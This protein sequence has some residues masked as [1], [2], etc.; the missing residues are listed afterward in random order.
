MAA[1]ICMKNHVLKNRACE[2]TDHE[3]SEILDVT[4]NAIASVAETPIR[5]MLVKSAQHML[6]Q[7]VGTHDYFCRL[8]TWLE[9]SDPLPRILASVL[10][11][12][13]LA[14]SN[15]TNNAATT[16][17]NELMMI[18]LP[19]LHLVIEATIMSLHQPP[20]PL[21]SGQTSPQHAVLLSTEIQAASLKMLFSCLLPS[22]PPYLQVQY[23]TN[24]WRA[25]S[26]W[27]RV[28]VRTLVAHT[29]A[30][31]FLFLL[32]THAPTRARTPRHN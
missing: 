25:C 29:R 12:R 18:A 4:T 28:L 19:R 3:Q 30:C 13:A 11:L 20:A 7:G 14:K 22:I 23:L 10:L 26:R 15:E 21:S 2:K 9:I 1:A 8:I 16:Q 27:V 17:F 5:K 6:E 32:D 31:S 24:R